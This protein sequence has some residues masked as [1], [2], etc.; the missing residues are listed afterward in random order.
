MKLLL[1]TLWKKLHLPANFQLRIMRL[2]QDQF[3]VGVTGIILNQKN[4]VLLFKHTY[5]QREWSLPGG[6]MKAM[7]HPKEGLEREIFEE[8]GLVVSADERCKIRTDRDNARLDIV[9]TGVYI[10]GEFTPSHEVTEG[11][12]FTFDTLPDIRESDLLLISGVLK[13]TTTLN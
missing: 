10:S 8:S 2:F 13:N 11:K 3:L 4:E 9:Y 1:A 5:R 12:F 6:Y 7:E